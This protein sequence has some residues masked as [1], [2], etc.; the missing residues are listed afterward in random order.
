MGR[1]R[2]LL[3]PTTLPTHGALSDYGKRITTTPLCLLV[4]LMGEAGEH[5]SP[6]VI[7]PVQVLTLMPL[8]G[9]VL[10]F[11]PLPPCRLTYTYSLRTSVLLKLTVAYIHA[12]TVTFSL[13]TRVFRLSQISCIRM[14]FSYFLF[15]SVAS[16]VNMFVADISLTEVIMQMLW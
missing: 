4:S 5:H 9:C 6:P 15:P 11:A 16:C 13:T 3:L 10:H 2:L 1:T 14:L 12:S 8:R 7:S